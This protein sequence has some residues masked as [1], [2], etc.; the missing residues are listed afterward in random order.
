MEPWLYFSSACQGVSELR[1]NSVFYQ[2]HLQ[3]WRSQVPIPAGGTL[4]HTGFMY[5]FK[6]NMYNQ[7]P[8]PSQG[9]VSSRVFRKR[10]IPN[11]L[12]PLS[13]T[14][15]LSLILKVKIPPLSSPLLFVFFPKCWGAPRSVR[16]A[17]NPWKVADWLCSPLNVIKEGCPEVC[18]CAICTCKSACAQGVYAGCVSLF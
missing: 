2:N 14:R 17:A 15:T 8:W 6:W 9:S 12:V 16:L 10:N 11:F 5:L 1:Q 3:W 18:V 7:M 13:L 4:E